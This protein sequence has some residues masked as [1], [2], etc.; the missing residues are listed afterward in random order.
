MNKHQRRARMTAAFSGGLTPRLTLALLVATALAAFA[1]DYAG[2]SVA[3]LRL[4]GSVLSSR[5]SAQQ[6][7]VIQQLSQL[8]ALPWVTASQPVAS[9][10][11]AP[12]ESLNCT[13]GC[14]LL[15]A[16]TIRQPQPLL[17]LRCGFPSR[18]P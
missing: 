8:Q 11:I 7:G 3:Q 6:H 17:G 2:A 1:T 9:G 13:T 4:A 12:V 16:R 5:C 15:I 14:T 10:V 18:A